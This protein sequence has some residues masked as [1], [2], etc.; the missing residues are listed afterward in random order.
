[1][2]LGSCAAGVGAVLAYKQVE[3]PRLELADTAF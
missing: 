3:A 1:M 2:G